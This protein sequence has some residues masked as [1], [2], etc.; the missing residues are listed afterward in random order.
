[1]RELVQ[2]VPDPELLLNL[3]PEE[4]GGKLLFLVRS[5][6]P[7]EAFHLGNL[8]DELWGSYVHTSVYPRKYEAQ[9]S[10]ALAEAWGWLRAQGLVV[11]SVESDKNGWYRLSRRA[12][13]FENPAEFRQFAAARI[14]TRE[15]LHPRIASPVWLAFMRGEFDV[16]VFQ[17]M[18]AVEVS[19]RQAARLP[20]SL[21]GVALI[22]EAFHPENGPL[23]DQKAEKGEREACSALF[24]G[25][26]G[27]YKNPQ[28]HRDVNLD[29][30][31]EA[32]EIIMM[33]SHLL[34][35]IDARKSVSS[36]S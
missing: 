7:S 11:E 1:M 28:S 4:L 12:L 14:L 36:T 24:A 33:A 2:T 8:N 29:N 3:T 15:A 21:I 5:R 13:S 19:V 20:D 26:V 17:A 25:A 35:V 6:M 31:V 9:I 34:R 16:A 22:R 30:L 23:T 32:A 27:M 18:K 10:L